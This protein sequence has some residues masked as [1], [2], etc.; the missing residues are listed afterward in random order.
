LR[1]VVASEAIT[2]F[3]GSLPYEVEAVG[4]CLGDW[5]PNGTRLVAD[6]SENIRPLG[7]VSILF[8]DGDGPWATWMRTTGEQSA[9]KIYLGKVEGAVLV[10]QL[11][12]PVACIIPDSEIEAV[13]PI[14]GGIGGTLQMSERDKAALALIVPFSIAR[15]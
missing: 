3:L 9:C 6:R 7:L 12:P 4:E 14:V 13:H 10:G 5:I 2:E 15:S 11:V 1:E 8:N